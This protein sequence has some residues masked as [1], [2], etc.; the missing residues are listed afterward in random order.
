MFCTFCGRELPDDSKFCPSCGASLVNEEPK[1]EEPQTSSYQQPTEPQINSYQQPAYN[2]PY[3]GGYRPSVDPYTL[4]KKKVA[5]FKIIAA[6]CNF[7]ALLP[8]TILALA[9][10]GVGTG[11]DEFE[12]IKL[13]DESLLN[14]FM[15]CG[16]VALIVCAIVFIMSIVGIVAP[17][18]GGVTCSL[19]ST[20]MCG[21]IIIWSS[22]VNAELISKSNEFDKLGFASESAQ[23]ISDMTIGLYVFI[24]AVGFFELISLIMCIIG[25]AIKKPVTNG[26]N[27]DSYMNM[28]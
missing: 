21:F 23:F 26:M 15:A 1:I 10:I 16:V 9:M 8:L 11:T 14:S 18:K 20:I 25:L 2:T 4:Y 28:R 3:Q 6:V 7:L 12:I 27:T 13:V 17:A 19:I 22:I 5:P 24:F